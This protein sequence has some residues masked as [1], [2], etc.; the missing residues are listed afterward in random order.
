MLKSEVKYS[1][2]SI[3]GAIHPR[4]AN[5]VDNLTYFKYCQRMSKASYEAEINDV[6][7]RLKE[8][9]EILN[10]SG[11]QDGFPKIHQGLLAKVDLRDYGLKSSK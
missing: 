8:L 6:E 4:V 1:P 5:L 2:Y 3:Q 7:S 9:C 10:L 11:L